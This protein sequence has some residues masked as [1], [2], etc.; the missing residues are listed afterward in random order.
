MSPHES[1]LPSSMLGTLQRMASEQPERRLFT[2]VDH[3]GHESGTMT[4]GSLCREA[5]SLAIVMRHRWHLAPGDR[6]LLVYPPSLEFIRAFVACLAAGLVPVP[7]YPV[8]PLRPGQGLATINAIAADCGARAA[9]T[10]TEYARYR[11]LGIVSGLFKLGGDKARTWPHLAWHRTD[12]PK[13]RDLDALEWHE[14]SDASEMAFLQYTSGSTGDPKGVVITHGNVMS[15]VRA[16]AVDLKFGKDSRLVCW[17][18]LFHDL[19]LISGVCNI[20]CGNGHLHFMSPTTFMA[21]PGVWFDVACRVGATHLAAPN[22]ALDLMVRRT[23]PEDRSRWNL[24]SVQVLLCAAEPIRAGT[25]ENFYAAFDACGLRRSTFHP[26]Y[27][28]AEH[29]VSVTMGGRSM[30]RFDRKA[31]ALGEVKA[32]GESQADALQLVGC[33]RVTKPGASVRIVDPATSM[34]C[35]PERVGEI[36]VDSDT[37]AAGYFGRDEQTRETFAASLADDPRQYLRTGDLGFFFEGELF[38]TGRLKDLIIVRGRNVHPQDLEESVRDCHPMVRPGGIAAFAPSDLDGAGKVVMLVETRD[39]NTD[40]KVAREVATSVRKRLAE[41]RQ[42]VNLVVVVGTR[43]LVL[44]T[45]SGKVRR[46]ACREAYEEGHR[47]FTDKTLLVD[48]ANVALVH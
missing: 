19:G 11:T 2:F 38:I 32:A 8:D 21:R 40:P 13:S 14:P 23:T 18:P 4:A 16:N 46:C 34:A 43:G 6:V 47:D 27:G 35:A 44:K 24:S 28:L 41:A 31:L 45:T 29:T 33:G 9:L 26:A 25:V 42:V 30:V 20:L 48:H 3:L 5:A 1:R 10:T 36:W 39:D 37:K 7:V 15:E 12:G 22:F 17:V